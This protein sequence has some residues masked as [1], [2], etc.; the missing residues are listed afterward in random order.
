[1][2]TVSED[3]QYR[4][5]INRALSEKAL[6]DSAFRVEFLAD[7]KKV[8]AEKTGQELPAGMI[9]SVHEESATHL[10]F[11]LPAA[12]TASGSQLSDEELEQVAGGTIPPG[13]PV[14][15]HLGMHGRNNAS[16]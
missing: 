7:P 6:N 8:I 12:A 4:G 11:V 3:L 10:H 14:P 9:V 5:D 16:W 1:M 2:P 15:S 13:F